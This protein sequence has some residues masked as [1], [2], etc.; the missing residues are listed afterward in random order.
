MN[1]NFELFHWDVHDKRIETN[2]MIL[3]DVHYETETVPVSFQTAGIWSDID[4]DKDTLWKTT[5][6]SRS[7]TMYAAGA[8]TGSIRIYNYPCDMP[9]IKHIARVYNNPVSPVLIM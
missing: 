2:R 8:S 3:R 1:S 9:S 4:T 6:R 5:A 7:N